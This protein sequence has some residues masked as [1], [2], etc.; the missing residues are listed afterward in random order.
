MGGLTLSENAWQKQAL[1]MARRLGWMCAHFP[2]AQTEEGRFRTTIAA[3]AKGYP[4]ATLVRERIIWV[5]FKAEKG[6]LRPQ[7]A[8]WLHALLEAGQEVYLARPSDSGALERVLKAR[9][10]QTAFVAGF[11]LMTETRLAVAKALAKQAA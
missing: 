11:N 8:V 5:E 4:D 10:S 6:P 3:D 2:T 1:E 7:Q 9:G